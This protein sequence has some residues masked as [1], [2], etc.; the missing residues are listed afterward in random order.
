MRLITVLLTAGLLL[1]GCLDEASEPQT[2]IDRTA[3]SEAEQ[4]LLTWTFLANLTTNGT[5]E[6]LGYYYHP[7]IPRN[8]G[9][10]DAEDFNCVQFLVRGLNVTGLRAVARWEPE[11][12]ET[13]RFLYHYL[14]ESTGPFR[15]TA[16]NTGPSPLLLTTD[17][18][19]SPKS[20]EWISFGVHPATGLPLWHG[21][22]DKVE[23]EIEIDYYGE[24]APT[25]HEYD[26]CS[27]R[28]QQ[29]A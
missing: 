16:N 8:I 2:A 27:P 6:A 14:K 20:T 19:L 5:T 10:Y 28:H 23:V 7:G 15:E 18:S 4:E 26:T 21:M 11:G 3:D 25:L 17:F 13:S 9:V 24:G 22:L 1:A 12:P 29:L